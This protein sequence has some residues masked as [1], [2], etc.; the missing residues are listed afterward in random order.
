MKTLSPTDV[1]IVG[2]GWTGLLMAKQLGQRTALKI[3]LLERGIMRRTEGYADD[4][5]ELDYFIRLRMMQDTS[6]DTVTLRR[7]LQ[8]AALPV[9]QLGCFLPGEGMGG[10]GEHWTAQFPRFQPDCFELYS[11]TIERYGS[12]RLPEDHAFQDWGVSYD[13]LD[14]YYTRAEKLV[15]VSGKVGNLRGK[16]IEGGNIFSGSYSAEYPNPPLKVA[17]YPQL[18]ANATTALGYHP[19]PVPAA[20]NSVPSTNPDGVTRP[21]CMYCGFCTR[22]GCM[23]GA[24]AQPTNT[25]LPL[26]DHMS[27]VTIRTRAAVRRIVHDKDGKAGKITGVTYID[28]NGEEMFQPANLV[29][30]ASWTFNNI[31][32]LLLSGIGERY[33]PATGKGTLGRNLTHQVVFAGAYAFYD[34]PL[35]RF[36]GGAAA[37]IQ[38]A[39][40]DGDVF[41][42]S[43]L[44]FLRGGTIAASA[45][46]TQP[47]SG[48]GT[49]PQSVK[50]RWGAEWKR[51]A[52]K[53]YDRSDGVICVA[54]HVPYKAHFYDLD[55]TYKDFAGDA[56]L[57][58]TIDWQENE[59]ETAKFMTAKAVEIAHAMGARD[60]NAFPG[61]DRYDVRRYQSTHVQGGTI[62]AA[63]PE[64]GVVNP[65]LQHWQVPNLFVLGGSTFPNQASANPTATILALTYR[66]ADAIVERYL[67]NPGLL[68]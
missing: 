66:T 6:R 35:N 54:E 67:K 15:S 18:F 43:N 41:D 31:R 16:R 64:H 25:L 56:L 60:I 7:N 27:H 23:I 59:R 46:G 3:V 37:G 20:M 44:Q 55:P 62:M 9:R 63:S 47:I 38:I 29:I 19:Y 24:K 42:H 12:K 11:K 26:V 5:D 10:A 30:L 1:V 22:F 28:E 39:D 8:E 14:P 58:L 65:Y 4:M 34:K 13:E 17:Y 53:W 36:M 32:L 40:F 45:Y 52:V 21:A 57:R 2:G 61:Y 50:S 48:F 33:D 51:E 49:V 68:A